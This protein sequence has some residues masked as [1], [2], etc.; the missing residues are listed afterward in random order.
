MILDRAAILAAEDRQFVEV[1]VPEWGG[2]VR[3]GSISAYQA[4]LYAEQADKLRD[5]TAGLS[6]LAFL[7]AACAVDEAGGPIF[8][9]ADVEALGRKSPAVL[10]RLAEASNK[11]NG[12]DKTREEIA[13]ES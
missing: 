1:D 5:G 13:G 10:G 3:L 11:L 9:Q 12:L 4:Q 2:A 7:V 6:V 8:T